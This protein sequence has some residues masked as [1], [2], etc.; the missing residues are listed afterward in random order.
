MSL[1]LSLTGIDSSN[2]LPGIYAEIRFA[3]GSAGGDTSPRRCLV[4]APKTSAG[5]I[6][7][8]TQVLGPISDEADAITYCGT[9]SP[10]HRMVRAFLAVNKT[11]ELY[12]ICPTAATGTAAVEKVTFVNAATG[13]GVASVY[14][15]GE[16]ISIAI[17]N[18]DAIATMATN[19]AQAINN[20]T[21]L[22]VTASAALGV[23]TITARIAGEELNTM[24]IRAEITSGITT[25]ISPT[26]D[27]PFGTSGVGGA[28][29]GIGTISYTS[30]LATILAKKFHYIVPH[31]M[32]AHDGSTPWAATP[33]TSVPVDAL[34]D[35]VSTQAEPSTGFRQKVIVGA[36]LTPSNA[37]TLASSVCNRARCRVINQEEAPEEHYVL[38]A[39]AAAVLMKYELSDPSYNFDFFGTKDGQ[40]FPVKRAYNDSAVP[41]ST[42]LKSMLNNG[43]TPVAVSETDNCYIARSVTTYCKNGSNY[44][45]RARDSIVV[46]VGD[47]FVDDM[48]AKLAAAPWTKVTTDPPE[49]GKEPPA[50]FA[51]PKRVKA[52]VET[53]VFDYRDAGWL[54][55]GKVA[56]LIA[57]IQVGQDP[58]VPSRMNISLP[59]YSAVLLHQFGLLVKE[60]SPAT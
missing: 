46:A 43:V 45:Y 24:R 54:D 12:V 58:V 55:P 36:A 17:A 16:K 25:T 60:A 1:A 3:Q 40:T 35:Q 19:L 38:A 7:V 18:G 29:A 23:V 49:G 34:L 28:T 33:G 30:A 14:L 42:E 15:C 9:G 57:S 4:I 41:T 56:D 2:P 13:A 39:K 10:A 5:S 50:D 31:Y 59:I 48:V 51:T 11:A 6:T 27:I 47:K 22:P 32:C 53:L 20:M 8:D 21:W 26:S 52:I 44:D 37:N